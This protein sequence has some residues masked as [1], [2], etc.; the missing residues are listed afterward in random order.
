[1]RN[2]VENGLYTERRGDRRSFHIGDL[3]WAALVMGVL[4]LVFFTTLIL[5]QVYKPGIRKHEK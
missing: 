5:L 4:L 3:T 2:T 1:M